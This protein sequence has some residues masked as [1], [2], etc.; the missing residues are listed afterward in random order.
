MNGKRWFAATALC[1][2]TAIGVTFAQD[3]PSPDDP[4]ANEPK[5]KESSLQPRPEDDPKTELWVAKLGAARPETLS[6]EQGV[7][8]HQCMSPEGDRF[9]YYRR[10]GSNDG[11]NGRPKTT[12]YALYTVGPD[13]SESKV[14][15]TGA[16]TTPPLFL[17][18]GRIL[19]T[20]RRYDLNE[21]G[22][23]DML[24]DPTLMVG[25]RD[26]GSLRQVATLNPGE[27]PVAVWH[28]DRDVLVSTPGEESANGWIVSLNLIRG[29]REN[30]VRGFNVEMVLDDG[31]L[32]FERQQ[33][34]P[35]DQPRGRRWNQ[36]G[37]PVVDDEN[38]E[39]AQPSLADFS[40]HIIFDPKDG[41]E[42]EL[43]GPNRR[44]RI[45]VH[46]EGSFFGHQEPDQSDDPFARF[47][48]WGPQMLS[49]QKSEIVII[50]DP[51][52]HDTRTPSARF[53]Y[54][55]IG[56][57]RDRGL[58]VIE[59]GNLGSRLILLDHALN[60]HRLADFDLNARGFM[61]SSDGLTIAW[62][63]VEDSDKNGYLQPWKDNSRIQFI[64]IE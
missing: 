51:Q 18:D 28:E 58:L 39:P 21:D 9:F 20:T 63:D 3:I 35:A 25:N 10:V 22:S 47:N 64:H 17:G 41:S 62:L 8:L 37:Q 44:S 42:V 36:W 32:L 31:R 52:H 16:D 34:P 19:F 2:V 33:P 55:T 30:I 60:T 46:A 4:P 61:A 14:A 57:I 6:T 54:Q 29:D 12:S 56:W 26:G 49:A 11:K 50:D 23:I 15:D 1:A 59:Q 24:D 38:A 40:A 45:V 27:V 13:K 43:Y 48:R 7:L 53:H 5:K